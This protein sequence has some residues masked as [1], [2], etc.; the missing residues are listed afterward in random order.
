MAAERSGIDTGELTPPPLPPGGDE[1][2]DIYGQLRRSAGSNGMSLNALSLHDVLAW[3][4]LYGV[5]L[6]AEEIDWLFEID[7]AVLAAMSEGT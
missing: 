4:T 7:A 5:T 6:D 2:L 3:Q 1:I